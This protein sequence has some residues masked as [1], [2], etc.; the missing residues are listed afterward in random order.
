MLKS[1]ELSKQILLA[2]MNSIHKLILIIVHR[3]Q[4]KIS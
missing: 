3:Q 2:I 1:N 4:I